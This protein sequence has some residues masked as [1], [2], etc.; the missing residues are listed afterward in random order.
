MNFSVSKALLAAMVFWLTVVFFSFGLFAPH[1]GTAVASLFAAGVSVSSAI[2]LILDMH[3]P[4][5]TVVQI[6]SAP[7]RSALAQL[8]H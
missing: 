6:S 7:I 5:A 3:T 4:Y 2:P 8:G 1:N